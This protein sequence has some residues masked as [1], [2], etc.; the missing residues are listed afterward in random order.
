[1]PVRP[2]IDRNRCEG[3]AACVAVCPT[4][5]F[6]VRLLTREERGPLTLGGHLHWA[7]YGGL[8]AVAVRGNDC[9]GCARCIA[10]C[11]EQA[12]RLETI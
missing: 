3:K 7:L 2:V 9:L 6:E 1:M 4:H 11:P 8:Q 5:V 10:E 12:I